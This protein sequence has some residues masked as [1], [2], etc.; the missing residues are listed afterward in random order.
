MTP[1]YVA[2]SDLQLR[3]PRLQKREIG[4][5]MERIKAE[6]LAKVFKGWKALEEL[7]LLSSEEKQE[8]GN[9]KLLKRET[10]EKITIQA[11]DV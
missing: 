3:R 11:K 5:K 8:W 9:Q 4:A 7:D 2:E 6:T 10:E 1:S